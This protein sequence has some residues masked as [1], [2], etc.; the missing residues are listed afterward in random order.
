MN[1][2]RAMLI[3]KV[4]FFFKFAFRMMNY[5][6]SISSWDLIVNHIWEPCICRGM[7]CVLCIMASQAP[8]DRREGKGVEWDVGAQLPRRPAPIPFRALPFPAIRWW[9]GCHDAKNARHTSA[10]ARLSNM[11]YCQIP[12]RNRMHVIHHAKIEFEKTNNL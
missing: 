9:F 5:M 10:D 12:W 8:S 3:L 1:V 4:I 7:T 2:Q 6:Y 11:I